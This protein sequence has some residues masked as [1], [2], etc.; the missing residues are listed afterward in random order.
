M[1]LLAIRID[2]ATDG[3]TMLPIKIKNLERHLG[4]D[5]PSIAA[6]SDFRG[7][8]PSETKRPATDLS[9]FALAGRADRR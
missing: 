2:Q 6:A 5:D 4:D 9:A 3:C 1:R 8:L 7:A